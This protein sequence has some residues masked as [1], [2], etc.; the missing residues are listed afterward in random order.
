M[1]TLSTDVPSPF[2][3]FGKRAA[4][5]WEAA[6]TQKRRRGACGPAGPAAFGCSQG[7]NAQKRSANVFAAAD[8]GARGLA[9][10]TA[11]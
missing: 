8:N 9:G 5:E 4:N 6:Q 2:N 1:T 3:I 10:S 7:E 11:L